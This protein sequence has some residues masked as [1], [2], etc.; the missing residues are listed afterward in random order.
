ML[1]WKLR[2]SSFCPLFL[3]LSVGATEK[4]LAPASCFLPFGNR[5]DPLA[6]FSMVILPHRLCSTPFVDI[7]MRKP[8]PP[9]QN[10]PS[11]NCCIY[12]PAAKLLPCHQHLTLPTKTQ[13]SLRLNASLF[14]FWHHLAGTTMPSYLSLSPPLSLI[15]STATRKLLQTANTQFRNRVLMSPKKRC[16]MARESLL[17]TGPPAEL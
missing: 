15:Y 4:N 3:P 5:E 17:P 10:T 2:G 13:G 9:I 16:P 1:R 14:L 6:V 8:T 12:H 7:S 11:I